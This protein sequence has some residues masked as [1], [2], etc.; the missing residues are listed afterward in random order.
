[1]LPAMP[2]TLFTC[3]G[4]VDPRGEKPEYRQADYAFRD[5]VRRES[6]FA[7]ALLDHLRATDPKRQPDRLVILGTSGSFWDN[8]LFRAVADD[9]ALEPLWTDCVRRARAR[10]LDTAFVA[11]LAAPLSRAC[12]IAVE[13]V[14]IPHASDLE[15]QA[16]V[17]RAIHD[18]VALGD[19][20]WLDV[21]HG[22]RH[23]PMLLLL[24]APLLRRLRR[25]RLHGIWSGA[26]DLTPRPDEP[27]P[28]TAPVVRLDGLLAAFDWLEAD[29]AFA[30]SGDL[31]H[32]AQ[33]FDRPPRRADLARS[34]RQAAG[35]ER[36]MQPELA[37]PDLRAV[38]DNLPREGIGGLFADRL[39]DHLAW[40]DGEA[41]AQQLGALA[42]R[43][44]DRGDLL[45][46]TLLAFEATEVAPPRFDEADRAAGDYAL[47][48]LRRIR[49][50]AAHAEPLAPG[51][52][53]ARLMH[54][55]DRLAQ[56]LRDHF[57][58]LLPDSRP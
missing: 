21:T 55:P 26:L 1:M 44:L 37:A 20:V 51:S 25:A 46:A 57:A 28:H 39:A 17:I 15:G 53:E 12:G 45:R 35:R 33:P 58:I 52:A 32:L 13:P 3:L 23:L 41:R 24:A 9:P 19:G 29:T 5:R 7:L 11:G 49:N 27:G 2:C 40:A 50:V 14:L 47:M 31:R 8:L 36:A 10:A 16:A 34:L 6:Y 48:R 43:Y 42:W 54:D 30:A 22:L 4:G 56:A 18:H 38:L